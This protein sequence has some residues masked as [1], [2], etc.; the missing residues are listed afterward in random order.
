MGLFKL[1][2]NSRWYNVLL[3]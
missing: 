2:F 3:F 1:K